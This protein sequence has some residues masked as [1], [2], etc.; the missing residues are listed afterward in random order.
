MPS[1]NVYAECPWYYSRSF[2]FEDAAAG[3][4]GSG[5]GANATSAPAAVLEVFFIDTVVFDAA[6]RA[7]LAA[8]LAASPAPWKAVVG[9]YPVYSAASS[10]GDTPNAQALIAE[11]KPLLETH[12]VQ[13]ALAGHDHNLQDIRVARP[14]DSIPRS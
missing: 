14:S 6:Q 8:A 12:G 5:S 13:L 11:L 3:G 4:A 10:H 2:A 1:R 9:H 7:W